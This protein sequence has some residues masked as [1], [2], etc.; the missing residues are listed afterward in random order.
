LTT[1]LLSLKSHIAVLVC[2]ADVSTCPRWRPVSSLLLCVVKRST[3]ARF[4]TQRAIKRSNRATSAA[5]WPTVRRTTDRQ[6]EHGG[7]RPSSASSRH[8]PCRVRQ[9]R[10]CRSRTSG[11]TVSTPR[12]PI[13]TSLS[14]KLLSEYVDLTWLFSHALNST[15]L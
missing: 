8:R 1:V 12:R 15:T 3:N 2:A 11:P 10:S 7:R 6:L 5:R 9:P 4:M 13:S 14:S